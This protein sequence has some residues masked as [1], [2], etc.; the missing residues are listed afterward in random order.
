MVPVPT[1]LGFYELRFYGRLPFFSA[2]R[3]RG[4]QGAASGKGQREECSSEQGPGMRWEG[5]GAGLMR[6]MCALPDPIP[7]NT[8]PKGGRRPDLRRP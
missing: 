2:G 5:I 4:R 3:L 1:F 8:E 6:E 7:P